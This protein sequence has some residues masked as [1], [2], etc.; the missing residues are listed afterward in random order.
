MARIPTYRMMPQ[1]RKGSKYGN[2]RVEADG[3]TFDSVK[4]MNRYMDLKYLL[5]AGEI[6]CLELQ[7]P[8]ELQPAFRDKNGKWHQAVRYICD[9]YYFDK[10][11]GRYVVEDV[12]GFKTEVYKLKKKLFEYRY[13]DLELLEVK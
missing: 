5:L 9:F 6:Q 12:K 1:R 8:F 3:H 10:H 2:R 4:E 7:K 11:L 13:P